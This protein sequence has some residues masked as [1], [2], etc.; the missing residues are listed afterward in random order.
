MSPLPEHH[1]LEMTNSFCFG[2]FLPPSFTECFRMFW[3]FFPNLLIIGRISRNIPRGQPF[4]VKLPC[5]WNLGTIGT[6][7]TYEPDS[8]WWGLGPFWDSKSLDSSHLMESFLSSILSIPRCIPRGWPAGLL[9][10]FWEWE[11]GDL[12][13]FFFFFLGA[14]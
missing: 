4:W 10:S 2:A 1:P 14:F 6:S 12:G 8:L 7:A 9:M 3:F 5:G 11:K 13:A